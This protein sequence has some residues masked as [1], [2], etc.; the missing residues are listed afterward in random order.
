MQYY[1]A[2]KYLSRNV[3]HLE[4]VNIVDQSVEK[5]KQ[6]AD[7]IHS[8][9][10]VAAGHEIEVCTGE[11]TR[12]TA[13]MIVC[14]INEYF[15]PVGKSSKGIYQLGGGIFK[16]N[17][18]EK[19]PSNPRGIPFCLAAGP[20]FPG[21]KHILHVPFHGKG[22]I[23]HIIAWAREKTITTLTVPLLGINAGKDLSVIYCFNHC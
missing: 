19:T 13:E 18:R 5:L 17:L 2:V 21:V 12:F 8:L 7:N 16:D 10:T 4:T 15:Q 22:V 20:D 11:L 23:S 1:R 6:V 3:Q 9:F 14:E